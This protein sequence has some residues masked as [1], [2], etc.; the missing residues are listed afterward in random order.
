MVSLIS[1]VFNEAKNIHKLVLS[2]KSQTVL[3]DEVVVVDAG[4][5]DATVASLKSGISHPNLNIIVENGVGR[6]AGR[7][8]A[9]KSSSSDI[10]VA[11]DAGTALSLNFVEALSKPL[12]S[13]PKIDVVCGFFKPDVSNFFEQCLASATIPILEEIEEDRFLPSSRS[14]AFRKTAWEKVGGYPEWLPICEDLIFDLKLKKAGYKFKF[15]PNVIAFWKPRESVRSFFKQYFLYA[16]GDGHAKL[17]AIRHLIRYSAYITGFLILYLS[18]SVS[19]LWL[20]PFFAAQLGYFSKFFYRYLGHFEHQDEF[21]IIKAVPLISF[22]VVVGDIAKM[23]GYP[24]GIYD[25]LSGKIKFET[26]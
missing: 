25:R 15:E 18:F 1:T 2:L 3:P 7:N 26:W 19:F 6:S 11:C 14:V 24:I 16:K 21:A 20:L 17:W 12:I 8:L 10:I 9:I 13:D 22:L 4:S 23:I 5:S